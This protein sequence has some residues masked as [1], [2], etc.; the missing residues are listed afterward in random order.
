MKSFLS[1]CLYTKSFPFVQHINNNNRALMISKFGRAYFTP[2]LTR[3]QTQSE[4]YSYP[5]L[6]I[7]QIVICHLNACYLQIVSNYFMCIHTLVLMLK[8]GTS[9]V[10]T[11]LL[12][13][14]FILTVTNWT[15][16]LFSTNIGDTLLVKRL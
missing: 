10:S 15:A 9:Y 2:I 11:H 12:S 3:Q 14:R 7:S 6:R 4:M 16:P 13:N 8:M 1:C 5:V